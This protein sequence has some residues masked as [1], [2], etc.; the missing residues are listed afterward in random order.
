M[1]VSREAWLA[2]V[3][4]GDDPV[5]QESEL[6]TIEFVDGAP[7]TIE[8]TDGRRITLLEP[9]GEPEA[10]TARQAAA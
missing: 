5:D 9:V 2:V 1:S 4:N 8:T 7:R 3:Q 6:V 10:G